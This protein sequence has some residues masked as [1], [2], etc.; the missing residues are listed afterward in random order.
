MFLATAYTEHG[1]N[2]EEKD[3]EPEI[4]MLRRLFFK[5]V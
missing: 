4:Q 1:Q 5:A 2:Q 3:E